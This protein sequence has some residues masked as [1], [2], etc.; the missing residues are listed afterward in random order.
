MQTILHRLETFLLRGPKDACR[1]LGVSY[2]NYMAMKSANG[3]PIPTYVK[4][5]A[6]TILALQADQLQKILRERLV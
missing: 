4:L 1:V 2:S 6:E 3:R 5:H